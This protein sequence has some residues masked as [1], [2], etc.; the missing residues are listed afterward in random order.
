MEADWQIQN[1]V[2]DMKQNH[3]KL[4]SKEFLPRPSPKNFAFVPFCHRG[5]HTDVIVS[6][7][8]T[9]LKILTRL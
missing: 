1:N 7:F 6:Y 9:G 5:K 2:T 3:V 4:N 8:K